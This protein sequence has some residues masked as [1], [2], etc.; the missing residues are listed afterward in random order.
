MNRQ[1]D[2]QWR[3]QR[4]SLGAGGDYHHVRVELVELT[5]VLVLHVETFGECLDDGLRPVE[6]AVLRTPGSTGERVR[7]QSRHELGC[8]IGGHDA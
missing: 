8:L 1:F 7:A 4:A 6:V 3:D 5:D 2:A